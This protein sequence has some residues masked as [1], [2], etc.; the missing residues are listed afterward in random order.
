[1]Y[2]NITF[3][4]VQLQHHCCR[5]ILFR[6]WW[7]DDVCLY[8]SNIF[9][10]H[11][12]IQNLLDRLSIIIYIWLQSKCLEATEIREPLHVRCLGS[13][14]LILTVLR[15]WLQEP[16]NGSRPSSLPD[17]TPGIL[18]VFKTVP[19]SL[20]RGALWVDDRLSREGGRCMD[21]QVTGGRFRRCVC[22]GLPILVSAL[23]PMA[24][25]ASG[26]ANFLV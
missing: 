13:P 2:Q 6:F 18:L 16:G 12:S 11:R 3:L 14:L 17:S 19:S 5:I 25:A 20:S 26:L 15:R 8:N 21:L 7:L 23:H 24:A 22:S 10:L 9:L 4:T 1:M